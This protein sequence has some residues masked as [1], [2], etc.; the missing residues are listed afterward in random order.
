MVCIFFFSQSSHQSL[1]RNL[2]RFLCQFARRM[3]NVVESGR[4]RRRIVGI[5]VDFV[6][7]DPPRRVVLLFARSLI[8]L[9]RMTWIS[10][11]CAPPRVSGDLW[12][13]FTQETRVF[14]FSLSPFQ[15]LLSQSIESLTSYCDEKGGGLH[16]VEE[17]DRNLIFF[18]RNCGY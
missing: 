4:E 3:T 10:C 15:I 7:L 6:G 12:N 18:F 5:R 2:D 13:I 1:K 8:L 14:F 11:P 9:Q 17:R 16:L